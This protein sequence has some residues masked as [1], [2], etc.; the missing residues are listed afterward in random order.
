MNA[1]AAG[2]RA[3]RGRHGVLINGT[4]TGNGLRTN[5][6]GTGSESS[7]RMSAPPPAAESTALP[8]L[9]TATLPRRVRRVLEHL[10]NN[11][12][13]E[14]ERLFALVLDDYEQQL[15][16]L[17]DHARN[18]DV[19]SVH[20][21]TLRT[22]RLN[23][24]DLLPRFMAGLEASVAALGRDPA[25]AGGKEPGE[26]APSFRNLSLVEDADIEEDA[27]LREI[28]VRSEARATLGLHLLGQRFGV[29]AGAPAFDA[30]RI[31]FGPNSLCRILRA[32]AQSLQVSLD[33]RLLLYR[34]FERRLLA[35]YPELV[36][37]L[38]AS[39]AADGILPSL[40]YVPVRVRPSVQQD[41]GK[42][43]DD[44][45][46][47]ARTRGRQG[48]APARAGDPN[49]G[50]TA[51]PGMDSGDAAGEDENAA[52][53]LLQ[54]LLG[55]RRQLLGKLRPEREG[56]AGHE[57]PTGEVVRA[58]G[59]L[60]REWAD[61]PPPKS[62]LDIKR[63]LLAQSRQ[64]KGRG[65]DFSRRDNDTFELLA[66]LY[67]QI[68]REVRSDTSASTLLKRLQL[69][70]LR[71]A[72][73]DRAFFVR[74]QHPARQLLNA[75][76]ESGAR[77]LGDDDV[78]PQLLNPLQQAV[79]HVI[80]HYDG[81]AA[82]FESSNRELQHQLQQYARKAEVT[83]RRHVEAARGKEKLEVAKRRAAE[84]IDEVVGEE[85][86][87]R[88]VRALLNQAWADVLTLTLLR[89]GADSPEWT[90]RL[91]MTRRIVATCGHDAGPPDAELARY[92]EQAL[93]QVG[94]HAEE[95]ATIAQR[96]TSAAEDDDD[97]ASRTEITMRLKAR[98]RLGEDAAEQRKPKLPPRTPEE[99]A[100][101]EQLRTMPYGTWLEFVTNQQGDVIRRRLSWYST[102]TDH[103]LFVN[104][105][106]Q[107]VAEM[108]L[109]AL[110]RM[111]ARDQARIVTAA[112]GRLI[113]RAWQATLSALRSFA[114]R[115]EKDDDGADGGAGGPGKGKA[116][117]K[118]GG[119][120][121][122][123]DIKG[124]GTAGP[125]GSAA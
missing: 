83:E 25:P 61:Q 105:R 94:Y 15:F 92:I 27:V 116:K 63:S 41:A 120:P 87:P 109:D 97:A 72:L 57:L 34:T 29:L 66:M 31:P 40:T 114:G 18:P 10:L 56:K 33:A 108:S 96:L 28:A 122:G 6:L 54:Q 113:D 107:R 11:A 65:A 3:G 32:A 2:G 103:A 125:A 123:K 4:G 88:F 99:Q 80:E 23:R 71:V 7:V 67:E 37:M 16:R 101:Y 1:R 9:A 13:S 26:P 38:N 53:D 5:A 84:T 19:E 112:R 48:P 79:E 55:G 46:P 98:T 36:E 95:A 74:N 121:G 20:L 35:S 8:T 69:P 89:Q 73:Q 111:V 59:D 124:G 91:E 43:A 102:V 104:Q 24:A 14:L 45:E 110:A 17:A 12:S 22:A 49:R 70:L 62:L 52:F 85:R 81:D 82:V 50:Y 39:V 75:V 76:A 77:W 93:S 118:G 60:Q 64:A 30:Q 44:A 47:R 86:L 100:R 68:Q 106:G 78:D 42:A 117:G 115:G 51:W 119:K 90:Q 58:L 21:Q